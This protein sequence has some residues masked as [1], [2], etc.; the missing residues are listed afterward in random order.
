MTA[1]SIKPTDRT[2]PAG[3]PGEGGAAGPHKSAPPSRRTVTEPPTPGHLGPTA[4]HFRGNVAAR[5]L[6]VALTWAGRGH[7]VIPCSRQNKRPLVGG[8]DGDRTPVELAPFHDLGQVERWWGQEYRGAHVGL[9]TRRLVVIDCDMP[10]APA[11]LGGRWAGCQDGTEVLARRLAEVGADWPETYTVL[12]PSGGVHLF[13]EQPADEPIGCRTGTGRRDPAADPA[14][15]HVGPLVDVRGVGGYVIAPGSYSS[16]QGHPYE[17]ISPAGT[18]PA[19]L[20]AALVQLLHKPAPPPAAPAASRTLL[21]CSSR[22]E[23]YARSALIGA[24]NDVL[25]APP[26]TGNALL[27]ARARRLAELAPTAPHV[28]TLATVE[29]HL[30]PAAV[31]RGGDWTDG[32]A[33]RTILSGWNRGQQGAA[34]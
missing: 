2:G 25:A 10:K 33:R 32:E 1:E 6:A 26:R 14:P 9:L 30:V 34:A 13:F 3:L 18:V 19:A 20:P 24:A 28:I 31:K 5:Q 23:R 21:T 22:A 8:F 29:E 12:T 16:A 17:R 11:P 7:G 27:F 15:G 4:V